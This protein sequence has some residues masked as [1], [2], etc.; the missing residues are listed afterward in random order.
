MS[1]IGILRPLRCKLPPAKLTNPAYYITGHDTAR[2]SDARSGQTNPHRHL[3]KN[4]GFGPARP[5]SH[6]WNARAS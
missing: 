1:R 2:G 3:A 5:K 4:P 6:F